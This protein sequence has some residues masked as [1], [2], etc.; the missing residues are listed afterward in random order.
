MEFAQ[1]LIA[2]EQ[3]AFWVANR[4]LRNRDDAR[5][6][7]QDAYCRALA[8]RETFDSG[9]PIRP[10][11]LQ[12][13]RNAALDRLRVIRRE[14][15]ETVEPAGVSRCPSDYAIAQEQR[16][17]VHLALHGLPERYRRALHLRYVEGYRYRE[18]SKALRVPIGTAQTLVHR[19][20]AA[21]RKQLSAP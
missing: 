15:S 16:N 2:F 13:V 19:G 17:T 21:L 20:R 3:A 12:I 11:F 4:I 18:I 10:W 5:D 7:V 1:R 6:V 8:Y 9:K 14:K